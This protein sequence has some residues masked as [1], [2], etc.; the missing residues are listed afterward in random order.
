M[1]GFHTDCI[2]LSTSLSSLS[3]CNH[4]NSKK[5]LRPKYSPTKTVNASDK[6]YNVPSS[7]ASALS[8]SVCHSMGKG[9]A[10][11]WVIG[12]PKL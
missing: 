2:V 8:A 7:S 3:F 1:L 6:S 12:T 11:Q 5:S 10:I 4:I 9:A